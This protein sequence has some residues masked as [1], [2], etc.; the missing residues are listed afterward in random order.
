MCMLAVVACAVRVACD[1]IAVWCV[2]WSTR[3][4]LVCGC[5]CHTSCVWPTMLHFFGRKLIAFQ[6]VAFKYFPEQLQSLA[7][8][9]LGLLETRKLLRPHLDR[10]PTE[11]LQKLC[12]RLGIMASGDGP[13]LDRQF[14]LEVLLQHHEKRQSQL[15]ELNALPLYPDEGL[16][17]DFNMVPEIMYMFE[18]PLALPKLN[19]QVCH[20]VP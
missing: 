17:W 8:C 4:P 1:F 16:V 7:M 11:L 14:L 6:R 18:A 3:A 13:L 2:I 5:Q 12:A 9:N 10:Q 15:D 19:L 20:T